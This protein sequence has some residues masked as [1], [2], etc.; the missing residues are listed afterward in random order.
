MQL[1]REKYA[2]RDVDTRKLRAGL[3]DPFIFNIRSSLDRNNDLD[4]FL[5]LYKHAKDGQLK[6]YDTFTDLCRVLEDRVTRECSSNSHAIKG[7]RYSKM[8]MDFAV[9]MRSHGHNSRRQFELLSSQLPLP[10]PRRV[11]YVINFF[12]P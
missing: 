8:Y 10:S 6:N 3:N 9:L 11:R 12:T 4:C 2:F 7:T 5:Q 1:Q